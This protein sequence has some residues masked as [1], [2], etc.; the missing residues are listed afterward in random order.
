MY[1]I[2][3]SILFC[4]TN[5][6]LGSTMFQP[7]SPLPNLQPPIPKQF[8]WQS[9]PSNLICSFLWWISQQGT[10]V[11]QICDACTAY[12]AGTQSQTQVAANLYECLAGRSCSAHNKQSTENNVLIPLHISLLLLDENPWPAFQTGCQAREFKKRHPWLEWREK[13]L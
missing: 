6:P 8:K 1:S 10:N 5:G 2:L 4:T 13:R 3:N 9:F 11:T 7:I 12:L